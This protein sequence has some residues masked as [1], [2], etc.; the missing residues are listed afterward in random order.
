VSNIDTLRASGMNVDEMPADV[1]AAL[2]RLDATEVAALVSIRE[3]LE[4]EVSAQVQPQQDG[5]VV[6]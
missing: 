3:K 6:F 5:N 2:E 4:P 1:Q